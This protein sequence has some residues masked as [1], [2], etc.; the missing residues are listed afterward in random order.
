M[1]TE[2]FIAAMLYSDH[3][4]AF[5]MEKCRRDGHIL[6][7][8][9]CL[10][11][12]CLFGW[13]VQTTSE[14]MSGQSERVAFSFRA[15]PMKDISSRKVGRNLCF[16]SQVKAC[17]AGSNR[18]TK[19]MME[20]TSFFPPYYQKYLIDTRREY[21]TSVKIQDLLKKCF[22]YFCFTRL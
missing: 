7:L 19:Q 1:K 2:L 3:C 4:T 6:L 17:L 8:E 15:Q 11:H 9:I 22:Y 12:E 20:N 18:G 5:Q 13:G 21:T 14:E 10:K 16:S